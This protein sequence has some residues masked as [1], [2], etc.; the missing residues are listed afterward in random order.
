M[1]DATRCLVRGA[2]AT[3]YKISRCVIMSLCKL[4]ELLLNN[5]SLCLFL[6]CLA[7]NLAALFSFDLNELKADDIYL[8]S[9][10][11][12]SF[13]IA[14]TKEHGGYLAKI[15]CNVMDELQ[16]Y[17]DSKE[18]VPSPTQ[19]DQEKKRKYPCDIGNSHALW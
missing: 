4:H 17:D 11:S 3:E 6:L 12:K 2:K 14:S 13:E 10:S 1:L 9:A 15:L 18:P 5:Y 16:S 19:T 7:F 8:D